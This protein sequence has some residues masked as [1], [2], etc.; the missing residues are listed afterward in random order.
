MT[1]EFSLP[2]RVYIED[3]DAGGIVYYVNYLKYFE[4]A[5]TELMRSLGQSKAAVREDGTQYVV[6]DASIS[7]RRP[8]VL[9]DELQVSAAVTS[10]G[11]ATLTF[12]QTVRRGQELLAEGQVQVACVDSAS[13]RPRRLDAQLRQ[14]LG[15]GKQRLRAA[16]IKGD[17]R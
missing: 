4:R 16:H 14:R 17:E 15:D 13:G 7:Y 11:A 10:V 3:T 6:T 12:R 5:R 2:L 9:D 1:P 8:A